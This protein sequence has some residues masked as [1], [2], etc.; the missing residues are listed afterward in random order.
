MECE[1]LTHPNLG[2]RLWQ[3]LAFSHRK[4]GGSLMTK[5]GVSGL[6]ASTQLVMVD[7]PEDSSKV[8]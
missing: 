7:L 2:V 3:S 6:E 1:G 5:A 8:C 4:S